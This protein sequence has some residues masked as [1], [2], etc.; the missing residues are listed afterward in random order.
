MD[1]H[2]IAHIFVGGNIGG[3]ES[4]FRDY[5]VSSLHNNIIISISTGGPLIEE[6]SNNG[7]RIYLLN[8]SINN[9]FNIILKLINIFRKEFIDTVIVH[10]ASPISHFCVQLIRFF[11]PSLIVISYAHG[12]AKNMYRYKDKKGMRIRK[13]ILQESLKKSDGV[14]AISKAVK[15]SLLSEFN[16]PEEKISVIYNGVDLN[17]FA[18][19]Q[20]KLQEKVRLMFVGRLIEL[21]GVQIVLRALTLVPDDVDWSFTVVGD[22]D[23]RKELEQITNTLGLSNRVEYLGNRR[24]IPKLLRD[25]DIFVHT[26]IGEEGF[27]ISILEAMA[28]GKVVIGSDAGAIPEI[29]DD[30]I[31]GFIVPKGDVECLAQLLNYLFQNKTIWNVIQDEAVKKAMTFS[32]DTF[33]SQLDGLVSCLHQ[34]RFD[35]K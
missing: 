19:S 24:D 4:L 17:R 33:V 11:M 18:M 13:K 25:A 7:I 30:G 15:E 10:H 23:Y 20:H 1:K 2:S 3:I 34:K 29:I 16:T 32:I 21:K 35:I 5:T 22:G 9:I 31:N 8:G 14:V 28:S 27:G 12:T 26:C 6:M